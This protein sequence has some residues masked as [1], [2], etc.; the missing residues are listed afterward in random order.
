M[1]N[2]KDLKKENESKDSSKKTEA[3]K[4]PTAEEAMAAAMASAMQKALA[5]YM[6]HLQPMLEFHKEVEGA[7]EDDLRIFWDVRIVRGKSTPFDSIKGSST[8]AG[9]LRQGAANDAAKA[10]QIEVEEKIA[11][12]LAGKLQIFVTNQ[13]FEAMGTPLIDNSTESE[14]TQAVVAEALG[15]A[16]REA[17]IEDANDTESP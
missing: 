3:A 11:K 10:I 17:G 9:I 15:F 13:T 14:A 6:E 8:L 4:K 12:P 16:H 1:K 2:N 5:P 7:E